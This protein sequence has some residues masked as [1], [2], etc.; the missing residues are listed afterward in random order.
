[1]SQEETVLDRRKGLEEIVGKDD[2]D[3]KA[4]REEHGEIDPF[5][6]DETEKHRKEMA[7]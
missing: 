6:H 7:I 2:K 3:T 1:M 4:E 5:K